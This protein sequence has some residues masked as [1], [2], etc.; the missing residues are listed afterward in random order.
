MKQKV[1]VVK[2]DSYEQL[3]IDNAIKESL[4][5][6]NFKIKPHSKILIKP[7]LVSQNTPEQH[8]ITHYTL[9]DFLCRYFINKKCS[10]TIGESSSFYIKGYT[11]RAFETS[12][13]SKIAKKYSVPLIAF[14]NEKIIPVSKKNLKFLDELYLPEIIKDYDLIVNVP[15][16]KTHM[17]MRFCGAVKNLF[18][19]IPGGYKQILHLKAKDINDM[20]NIF[21]DIYKSIKPPILSVAD[22][23]IGLDGGPAAVIGKPKKIGY[24]LASMNPFALDAVACQMI[25]YST[26]DITTITLAEKRKV[27]NLEDVKIIGDFKKVIFKN[28]SKG[29]VNP[30]KSSL[31]ITKTH[32]F[33]KAD[34]KCNLCGKCVSYC[35]VKALKIENDKLKVDKIKCISCYSCIPICP[36]KALNL[37]QFKINWIIA[38]LRKIFRI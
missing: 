32:A 14:E 19:F 13:I 11:I 2:C 30:S 31:L 38:F 24:V 20:A 15:K 1:S 16:I 10:V 21:L 5:K 17:Y 4:E 29:P 23:I 8:S 36:K 25:G 35:P 7:N 9:I 27:L 37:Q 3:Q 28:L 34:S 18:G 26:K 12:L 22:G 33:P 6:I